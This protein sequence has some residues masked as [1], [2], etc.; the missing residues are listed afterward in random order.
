M[1]HGCK[2][3]KCNRL[4]GRKGNKKVIAHRCSKE[5]YRVVVPGVGQSIVAIRTNRRILV[6]VA[7]HK[8]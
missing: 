4:S 3:D 8:A 5:E 6:L 1:S 7:L 2:W